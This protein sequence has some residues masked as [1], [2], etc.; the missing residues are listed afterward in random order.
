MR[1]AL[2]ANIVREREIL[3]S[4]ASSIPSDQEFVAKHLCE[5]C[6]LDRFYIGFIGTHL[7]FCYY[8]YT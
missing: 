2:P 5:R 1:V 6:L 4:R 7:Q 8:F 3:F